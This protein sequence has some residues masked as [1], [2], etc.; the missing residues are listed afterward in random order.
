[1][2]KFGGLVHTLNVH[3]GVRRYFEIGNALVKA[4]H[5]FTLFASILQEKNPWMEFLGDVK[6]YNEYIFSPVD[7]MLTNAPPCFFDLKKSKA[8]VKVIFVASKFNSDEYKNMWNRVGSK[9]LWIGVASEWNVGMEEIQGRCIPGGVNTKFFIP[10]SI[11]EQHEKLQVC[12]YARYGQ[13]SSSRGTDLIDNLARTLKKT[14]SFV[15]Y[16]APKYPVLT[17]ANII[18]ETIYNQDMLVD[19][20]RR[21]DIIMSAMNL[22]GWNNV[23]AEGCACGLVP[24]STS[25]GVK[26]LVINGWNGYIIPRNEFV[27]VACDRI[28]R[29]NVDREL[30]MNM[31]ERSIQHVQQFDWEIFCRGML[32]EIEEFKRNGKS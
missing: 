1:M 17:S 28:N 6:P 21:S 31:K 12:F 16:D 32:D 10:P 8:D 15:G 23:I 9:Y 13:G 27:D 4:G 26:D 20:L 24:I 29:L 22:A 3:G 2:A 5:S 30:L 19:V 14:I 7:V 25:A 18:N 11:I